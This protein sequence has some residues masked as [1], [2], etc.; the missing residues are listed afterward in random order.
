[1]KNIVF[2]FGAVLFVWQPAQLVAQ[3]FPE[4]CG[5]PDQ[6]RELAAA[7]FNH[8][9]W[10]GFDG[11][12]VALDEVISRSAVR[13]DLPHARLHRLLAPIGEQ[14]A[15]IACNIELLDRLRGRRDRVGDIALY[16]LSNM[17][18]PFAR[19]LERQHEFLQWFDGGIFSSDVKLGKPDPAIFSLLAS[20]YRLEAA[21]TLF[22]DDSLANVQAADALGWQTIHCEV[23]EC[24]P[25]QFMDEKG[26]FRSTGVP[27]LLSK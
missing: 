1:M 9:D 19:A 12:T 17:P 6:A 16:F 15:P 7:L 22:I 20:R 3:H 25:G 18:D 2:D 4:R 8:A 23:P 27:G 26:F 14:L 13:L 11:G 5:T 10:H 24:L 21:D